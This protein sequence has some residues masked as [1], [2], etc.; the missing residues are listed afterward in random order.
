[1]MQ[2]QSLTRL[3]LTSCMFAVGTLLTGCTLQETATSNSV[4]PGAAISGQVH[5]GQQAIS[6]AK[7]YL[8]SLIHI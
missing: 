6:G 5:G 8:L 7:V 1:M 4:I 2:K 3:A